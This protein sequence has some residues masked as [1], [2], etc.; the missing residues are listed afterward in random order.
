LLTT[1]D[2]FPLEVHLFEGNKAETKTLIPVLTRFRERGIRPVTS[3]WWPMP[4][5][6]PRRT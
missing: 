3:S 2:G 4:G 5:C 6:C 1:A